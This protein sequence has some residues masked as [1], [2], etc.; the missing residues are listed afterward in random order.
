MDSQALEICS[1]GGKIQAVIL[2]LTIKILQVV[3]LQKR[4]IRLQISQYEIR[5]SILSMVSEQ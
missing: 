4:K 2:Q 3:F 5:S 1:V